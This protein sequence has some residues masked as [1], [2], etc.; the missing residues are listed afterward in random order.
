VDTTL[1][2]MATALADAE[3][4]D[5]LLSLEQA[6]GLLRLSH[7]EETARKVLTVFL[8][9]GLLADEVGPGKSPGVSPLARGVYN[10]Q[11][12]HSA[13]DMLS[14]VDYEER[15]RDRRAAA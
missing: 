12:R 4:F 7:Q 13:I 6:V 10:R 8:G 11:R 15:S 14:P 9:R 5:R 3:S 1:A 2:L